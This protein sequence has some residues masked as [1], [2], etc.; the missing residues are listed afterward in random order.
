LYGL[1]EDRRALG[2]AATT[3][4]N[5]TS[6]PAGYYELDEHL[7]LVKKTDD[8]T[9]SF[10]RECFAIPKQ[11]VTID[12]ASVLVVDDKGRRWRLPFGPA[13]YTAATNAGELRICREVATERDLFSCHGT[14]YELPAENADGYA[15]IRP[16]A[17][18]P[19]G[20]QD[21]ASY[22]GM[23]VMTGISP[24][25]MKG[26][27]N[28][29]VI[30]ADDGAAA[31]WVG[32][33]DDLWKLGKPVGQGGPWNRTQIEASI[34]S[35]PYLIAFYDKRSLRL[36]HDSE[37]AVTFTLQADPT[38]Q[39]MWVDYEQWKVAP[40]ENIDYVFPV[41]FQARWIRLISDTDCRA[42][43]RLTYE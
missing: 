6:R 32:A 8:T 40:G 20:I 39:G 15:K 10:I 4:T 3:V 9:E 30:V 34:P 27:S 13:P 1:G 36:L 19:Y 21:Y 24:E 11:V 14:F 37:K 12:D 43:A 35:D 16:V 38:G 29:H 2:V 28:E 33:I 26:D 25:R 17:S 31:V 41:A 5:G 22:R 23:L 42:T 7:K 18:H